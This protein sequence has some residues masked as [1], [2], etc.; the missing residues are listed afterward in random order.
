LR[1]IILA[2]ALAA[3][4]VPAFA[5]A[6]WTTT[7]VRPSSQYGFVAGDVIWNCDNSGCKSTSDTSDADP[8]SACQQLAHQLGTLSSFAGPKAFAADRLSKCN[9][10][11]SKAH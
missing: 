3:L 6:S 4:A 11:A 2:A 8:M 9:E 1:T 7:P 10:H 5:D